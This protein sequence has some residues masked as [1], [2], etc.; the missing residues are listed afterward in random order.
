M[1]QRDLIALGYDPGDANGQMST[2]TIVAISKF[3]AENG[4][5]V[6]GEASPQLAGILSA[7][8]DAAGRQNGALSG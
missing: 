8:R 6:T 2:Q 7:K 3:Q 1:I 4:L 5:E